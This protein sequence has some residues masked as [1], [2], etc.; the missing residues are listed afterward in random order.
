MFIYENNSSG[1]KYQHFVTQYDW[2]AYP[3][4][5]SGELTPAKSELL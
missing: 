3:L 4:P 2:H 1:I 5:S